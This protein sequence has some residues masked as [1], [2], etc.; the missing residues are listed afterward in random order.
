MIREFLDPVAALPR[1]RR[2][3]PWFMRNSV[4]PQHARP[5]PESGFG[6]LKTQP[7]RPIHPG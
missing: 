6:Q 4:A 3:L 5:K 1:P 7:D 2:C